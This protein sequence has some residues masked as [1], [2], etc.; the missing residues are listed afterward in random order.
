MAR[1]RV[2]GKSRHNPNYSID[3][4]AWQVLVFGR[5]RMP[6]HRKELTH[7][8]LFIWNNL[9]A[10]KD[11]VEIAAQLGVSSGNIETHLSTMRTK[12]WDC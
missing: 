9:D 12:G 4:R 1:P 6:T 2:Q 5:Y 8:Q 7:L 3:D 10:G 11:R